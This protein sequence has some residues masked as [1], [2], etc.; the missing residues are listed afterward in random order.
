MSKPSILDISF[1]VSNQDSY[2]ANNMPVFD[3]INPVWDMTN[4]EQ[5]LRLMMNDDASIKW[6]SRRG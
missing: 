2:I 6:P 4:S 5:E 3:L 1:I